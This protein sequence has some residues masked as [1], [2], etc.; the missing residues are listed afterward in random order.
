MKTPSVAQTLEV[1]LS[2]T[3]MLA[4]ILL[5]GCAAANNRDAVALPL[6]NVSTRSDDKIDETMRNRI[7]RHRFVDIA[8]QF[9]TTNPSPSS[10]PKA[11]DAAIVLNLFEDT[12]LSALR[13][14]LESRSETKFT[15]LGKIDGVEDSRVTLA[16]EDSVVVGNLR[17][18]N[19]FY[20]I[21][22]SSN[23]SHVIYQINQR[24]FPGES[25]PVARPKN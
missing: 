12:V 22:Y 2:M 21:R 23:G 4:S 8:P 6:F 5:I 10:G 25:A 20:S 9:L 3:L 24:A 19:D 17:L 14:G 16:V 11:T 13:E 1:L 18:R 15:W 7:L